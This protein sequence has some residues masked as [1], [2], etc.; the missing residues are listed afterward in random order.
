M[1]ALLLLALLLAACAAA[2]RQA[3]RGARR[4]FS[5][6]SRSTSERRFRSTSPAESTWRA[7]AVTDA[8]GSQSAAAADMA[9]VLQVCL[10]FPVLT[11]WTYGEG[12]R[13]APASGPAR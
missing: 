4:G 9:T 1:R 12:L 10:G 8:D 6:G 2:R 13:T 7:D 3:R 5:S 11:A